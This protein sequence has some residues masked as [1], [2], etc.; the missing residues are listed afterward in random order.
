MTA[1][2]TD[3]LAAIDAATEERCCC[4]CGTPLPADSASAYFASPDCQRAWN[5]RQA[6]NPAAVRGSTSVDRDQARWRPELLTDEPDDLRLLDAAPGSYT[7]SLFA[8]V[9]ER[10]DGGLWHLRLHDGNRFVGVDFNPDPAD[11]QE[12][13]AEA[14]LR[15]ERE[16]TD[17]RRLAEDDPFERLYLDGVVT[18]F[19]WRQLTGILEPGTYV[20]FN[21]EAERRQA[22][23]AR[24][25]EAYSRRIYLFGEACRPLV[26]EVRR[27]C[28]DHAASESEPTDPME[29]ALWLRRNRNTGPAQQ[30]RAPRRI[31]PRRN[32]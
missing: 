31:D 28:V 32:R 12:R 22:D 20:T 6:T 5:E 3:V 26:D 11:P 8:T 17:P 14:W 15:L 23:R 19:Q 30:Q 9:F 27:L 7:G 16:L 25:E 13:L 24:A 29:R 10:T 21:P 18:A 4:G 1:P 2:M